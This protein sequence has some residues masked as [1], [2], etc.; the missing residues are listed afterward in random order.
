MSYQSPLPHFRPP[1]TPKLVKISVI[2]TLILSLLSL[3]FHTLFTQILHLPSPQLFLSLS[4]WGIHKFFLWQFLSYLF[5][6]PFFGKEISFSLI[7]HIFFD[8]YILWKIGTTIYKERG[9]RDF[10]SLYFGGG[11]FVGLIA[12]LFLYLSHSPALLS[13]STYSIYILLIAWSFLYPD[14]M[15]AL[16]FLIP[17]RAKWVIFSFIGVQLFLDL[18]NGLF[19]DFFV[20]A[21]A[22]A[23]GYFYSLLIFERVSPF[24]NLH[25][26]DRAL[27][28]LKQK[29]SGRAS[30]IAYSS[31]IYEF[32]TRKDLFDEEQF[33]DNC[34]E[35]IALHGK[36]S[37]S[38][39]ERWRLKR[40]SKL[41]KRNT[42]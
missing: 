29:L 5:I 40:I 41:R 1:S 4:S 27:L 7:L 18:S 37:L 23:F 28:T 8:L 25:S 34:L 15:L 33:I 17:L 32:K 3:L 10:I 9:K 12:Y 19:L 22:M 21:A 13:G 14:A 38:W 42:L 26:F 31:N 16:F 11:I 2:L 20:T 35:K 24:P 30:T 36:S 39:K 6:Q